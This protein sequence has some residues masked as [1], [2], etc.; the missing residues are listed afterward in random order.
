VL[1]PSVNRDNTPAAPLDRV[2]R[3]GLHRLEETLRV[4][5][6]MREHPKMAR[7][8]GDMALK[9]SVSKA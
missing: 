2:A 3:A 4:Q 9:T 1:K 7:L 8:I 5:A 6:M